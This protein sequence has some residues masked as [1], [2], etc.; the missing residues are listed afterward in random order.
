MPAV[1]VVVG[2][3]ER[4]WARKAERKFAKKGRLP[5]GRV[6]ILIV[7]SGVEVGGPGRR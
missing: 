2:T 6:G 5:E 1:L 7:E 3:F 4:V